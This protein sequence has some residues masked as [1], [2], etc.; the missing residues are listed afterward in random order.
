FPGLIHFGL[1]QPPLIRKGKLQFVPVFIDRIAAQ[2]RIKCLYFNPSNSLHGVPDRFL[3]K[4]NLLP[5]VQ[6]LPFATPAMIEMRTRW[7]Y[8]VSGISS[9]FMKFSVPQAFFL[10]QQ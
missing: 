7:F 5:V 6:V 9:D 4:L 10:P 1:C 2:N 3:F 8:P